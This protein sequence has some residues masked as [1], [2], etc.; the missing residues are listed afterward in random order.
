MTGG[1]LGNLLARVKLSY[2]SSYLAKRLNTFILNV[3]ASIDNFCRPGIYPPRI[4]REWLKLLSEF[5]H[6]S[7]YHYDAGSRMLRL[8]RLCR[9]SNLKRQSRGIRCTSCGPESCDSN[10]MGPSLGTYKFLCTPW[11]HFRIPDYRFSSFLFWVIIPAFVRGVLVP[12]KLEHLVGF[13]YQQLICSQI[14]ASVSYLGPAFTQRSICEYVR[15][16][17]KEREHILSSV[18]PSCVS[19]SATPYSG[20]P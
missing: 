10:I 1:S 5:S 17:P 19:P 3:L 20:W 2:G 15:K 7:A 14:Q 6:A 13:H 18:C 8:R 9:S 11:Y 12:K 4:S 16:A